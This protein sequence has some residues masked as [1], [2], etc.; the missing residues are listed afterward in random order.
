VAT[1]AELFSFSWN[2][3]VPLTGTRK[4]P[5]SN[6]SPGGNKSKHPD[7]EHLPPA[8]LHLLKQSQFAGYQSQAQIQLQM[9]A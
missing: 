8:V 2:I 4:D 7:T 1:S 9:R 3:R 6:F 5:Q